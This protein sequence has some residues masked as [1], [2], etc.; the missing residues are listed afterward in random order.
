MNWELIN[1]IFIVLIMYELVRAALRTLS[2]MLLRRL[3]PSIYE[4]GRRENQWN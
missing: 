1:T 2:I 3:F 4:E